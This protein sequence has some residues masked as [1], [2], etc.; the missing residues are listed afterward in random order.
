VTELYATLIDGSRYA[1][2]VN[3]VA[4]IALSKTFLELQD[5]TKRKGDYTKSFDLPRT[6]RND[7]FFGLFGDPSSIG[8]GYNPQ[9][10]ST[11]WLLEDS[12]IVIEGVLKLES[13]DYKH[14]RYTVS[15]AGTVAQIKDGI[16][17]KGLSDLDMSA[18]AFLPANIQAS[19]NRSLW[20]GHVVFSL[21]DNGFGVGLYKKKNTGNVI[22]DITDPACTDSIYLDRTIPAFRLN[23]LIR[24]IFADAGFELSGSWFSET[25][26]EDIYVQADNPLSS[27]TQ[28]ISLFT[29]VPNGGTTLSSSYQIVKMG[30]TPT[31]G[32]FNNATY[33]YTAPVAGNYTFNVGIQV[34]AGLPCGVILS[35]DLRK[36]SVAVTTW[37][38]DWCV[39]GGGNYTVALA[40]GDIVNLYMKTDG[41]ETKPGR[42][43]VG[44]LVTL[45]L[46]SATATGTS[47]DPSEYLAN[48]KQI[49]FLREV[50][51]IFNLIVWKPSTEEVRLDTYDYFMANYGSKK[52]WSNKV[53]LSIEPKIS[54][55]NS[56]LQNPINLELKQAEDILNKEYIQAVGRSYGSYRED[57]GIP[58]TKGPQAPFKVFAPAPYQ[59]FSSA[60]AAASIPQIIAGK[61][62]GSEDDITFKPPGLQLVYYCGTYTLSPA[63]LYTQDTAASSCVQRL[64]VPVFSPFLLTAGAWPYSGTDWRVQVATLDLNFTWFTPPSSNVDNPATNNLYERYFKEMLRERYDIANKIIEFNAILKPEDIT[65]FSFADTIIINLNGTPVGLKI[66][67]IKDYSP[68]IEKS[69]KIKAMISFIK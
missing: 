4:P 55:I 45:T 68:N 62:Y 32:E 27:Y 28:A 51:S 33:T 57:T 2:D 50:V 59:E 38:H 47:V 54:P 13:T 36:N 9:Y 43:G 14:N 60:V 64:Y 11:C 23:E 30:V 42:V 40:A 37:N 58:F 69:T 21:N 1:L 18:W 12:N 6:P 39:A 63:V 19:W 17:D 5:F 8:S 65:N 67:E 41:T 34:S 22:I 49:D 35:T 61:L 56:E 15:I 29:A 16:G 44:D 7:F 25:N 53:D 46:V 66:L 52:D 31:I 26:V 3:P 24:M 20:S 48:Y 10:I